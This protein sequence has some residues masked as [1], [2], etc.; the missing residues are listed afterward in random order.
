V[1]LVPPVEPPKFERSGTPLKDARRGTRRAR[2]DGTE[3]DCPVYE[4]EQLDVGSTFAGP[5]ILEQLDC[6]TVVRPGQ[7]AR[8]DEWKSLIV[9]QES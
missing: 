5:A 2:F 1:G 7:T 4:R 6:T 8:V 9:T 3:F